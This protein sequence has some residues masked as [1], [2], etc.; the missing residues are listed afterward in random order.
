ML[1]RPDR[2]GEL[3]VN[4]LSSRGGT[5]STL[6]FVNLLCLVCHTALLFCFFQNGKRYAFLMLRSKIVSVDEHI[7]LLEESTARNP[8]FD[9]DRFESADMDK[10]FQMLSKLQF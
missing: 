6:A 1:P 7:V 4:S 10:L 8:E 5:R 9:D 3:F 2:N